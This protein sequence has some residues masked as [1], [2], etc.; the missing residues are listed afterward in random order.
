M[1][2]EIKSFSP[3]SANKFRDTKYWA[4]LPESYRNTFDVT[5]L[6]LPFRV[7]EFVLD[8]LI[9][10][11][12]G[13]S[14]PL[15][16]LVFPQHGMLTESQFNR[17]DQARSR[18]R[19]DL[20]SEIRQVRSELNPHPS[21]QALNIPVLDEIKLGGIQHK[22]RETVLFFPSAG[23]SCHAYC[24]FCFRW[25]QFVGESEDRFQSRDVDQLVQYLQH[26]PE[27]TDILITG[28]DPMIM[29]TKVLERYILPLLEKTA[30]STIRFG[31]KALTY[32]PYRFTTDNDA[33]ELL[34]LFEKI[35]KSGRHVAFMA[36]FNHPRELEPKET[37]KAIGR[38]LAT[39]AIIRTQAPLLRHINDNVQNWID[40][41]TK[42]VRL[43]CI[44]YY[45]FVERDTGPKQYFE[46]PLSKGY[47]IFQAAYSQIS[48]LARS[49]RGPIMSA[50]SGKVMVDGILEFDGKKYF[51]LQ[52]LQAR[53][54]HLCRRP[55]LAAYDSNAV[56]FDQLKPVTFPNPDRLPVFDQAV[57][58][59]G[60]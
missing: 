27:V 30:V 39:G 42:Q 12:A 33:D 25:A 54:P 47:E 19:T 48:G 58:D 20:V 59:A 52:Y 1:L 31:S 37:Q 49:V 45:M 16:Q 7:N 55:F 14:D 44:P 3:M 35:V 21:G 17:I 18:E 38:I 29:R 60:A 8:N 4:K 10:W 9:D 41:W 5:S 2:S 26:H 28:G 36:H 23:Q 56:W 50:T 24:S 32:W 43:G 22:Y 40:L 11:D 15:F 34:L 6:V 53:E 51:S 46:V 13:V 57:R